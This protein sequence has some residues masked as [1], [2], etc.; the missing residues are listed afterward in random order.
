VKCQ[1]IS[2]LE[3]PAKTQR[4]FTMKNTKFMKVS[5]TAVDT[6]TELSTSS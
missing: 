2:G 3:H 1:P 4:L 6:E 5:P